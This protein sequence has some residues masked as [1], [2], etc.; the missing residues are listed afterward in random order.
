MKKS[1][2]LSA[3]ISPE[4]YKIIL[5]PNLDSFTFSGEETIYL[6]IEKPVKEIILHS[7]ELVIKSAEFIHQNEEIWVGS[8]KYNEKA[9]TATFT[10]PKSLPKGVG[11]LKLIFEGVL[12]DKMR[13]FYR[14]KYNHQDQVKYLATTQFESTDARRA[15]PCFDE[16]SKK[17]IFDV[18]LIIP[19]KLTAISNTLPAVVREHEQGIKIV[20][21]EPTPKMSTYLLAF[22]VGDFEYIEGRTHPSRENDK[23]TLCRVFVTPG[24]LKQAQFA[25][26]VTIKILEF[27]EEYFKIAYPLPVMDMIAIPDFSAGAME[28]W[29]AVTYRETALLIDPENSAASNKQRVAIVIAHELAH[30]W[31]GN[32]VTMDWWTNLWLNEGF[33]SYIEYLA[34]NEVFPE[35]DIWTQFV[36]LDQGSALGLDSLANTHP[37]EVEVKH[38]DEISEIFDAVSYSKGASVIRMLANYLGYNDFR[39]GLRYYL[40]KYQYSNAKTEDLW[41][42]FEFVS[43]KP[44]T[45][46]M[47]N[48]TKKP[49]YPII[50]VEEDKNGL[51]LSQS[52]FYASPKSKKQSLDTTLWSIP[53]KIQNSNLKIQNYLL[54]KKSI[55]IPKPREGEWIKLNANESSFIRID[56]PAKYLHLLK[57]ALKMGALE[58]IDRLGLVRDVFDLAE[59]DRLPT[60]EALNLTTSYKS[61]TDYSV[62]LT[63]ASRLGEVDNLI[64]ETSFYDQFRNFSREIYQNIAKSLGWEKQPNESH[65]QTLLRSL[66]L[67][68]YGSNGGEEAIKKAQE[69]FT[70]H[71][72]PRLDRGSSDKAEVLDSHFRGNDKGL[73]PDLRAVVYNLVAENGEKAEFQSLMDLYKQTDFQ[74]ERD[75][76]IRALAL[77]KD[78]KILLKSLEFAMSDQVRSQ[79]AIFALSAISHNPKGRNLAWEFIQEHWKEIKE[80][81]AGAHFLLPRLIESLNTFTTLKKAKEIEAFFK[82][83]P[84]P[85][86]QRT[87]LQ[88]L[89]KIESNA[90]WLKRDKEKIA[91]FLNQS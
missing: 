39:D 41:K 31:F 61:E 14:S 47:Q 71:C 50:T 58:P 25:L 9:E 17:A 34:V 2:R 84:A 82:K 56:Y 3:H 44:V 49:G 54:E 20:E 91:K 45:K 33:A 53:L 16:P 59:A 77:F 89:E 67:Y 76:I 4:R 13:G 29:G 10:F 68:G 27:Y 73:D 80:R 24:K 42:A 75:R 30:Q 23:G 1:V 74:Q 87:I 12:N 64:D 57:Q 63:L 22:I 40:K 35:W 7:S 32:L 28:N 69:L 51:S 46:I 11:Q 86:A 85:E 60:H 62:W 21:F 65:T 66:A 70:A 88:V 43:K 36:Y 8:I 15:F 78:Q 83:N 6:K 19:E 81:Y 18:S 55:Q 52:R 5:R 79:D 26:E 37:I 90:A 38:P 48:W 72:H